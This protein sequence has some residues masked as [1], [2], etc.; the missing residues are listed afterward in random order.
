M[1]LFVSGLSYRTAPVGVREQLALEDDKLREIL[2]DVHATGAVGEALVVSTCNRVEVYGMAEVPG[3]A[4]AI[5][6]RHLCRHRGVDP[7][8]VEPY[9]YTHLEREAV[10]HA[11][12]VAAS[13]D[14]MIVGEPQILGQVKDAFALA[15]SCETIGPALHALFTQ[16]FAVAKKVRTETEIGRHAV[17][18]S[19]AA[20]ELAKKIFSGLG[21]KAVLLV[22]AGKMGELAARHLVEQGAFPIYV[23]NRTWGR[24]QEM[25]RALAGTAVPFDE[26]ATALAAVDIVI[27]ST[28]A[29]API[30]RRD[31]VARVMQGRRA[32]PLF[33]IDIAVPRDVE[34]GVNTLD[35]VYCYD[36]DD[37]RKVVDANRRERLREAERGEAMI[38]REV[39]KFL[40]R[41]ADVAVVPTIV[42]LRERLEV[43]RAGEVK[44]ALTR[45]PSA[46]AETREALEALSTAIV[47]K[48]L[49]APITKLRESSRA[50]SGRSWTEVI[51]ELFGLGRKP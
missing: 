11:F 33:F 3:E 26:L 50:G 40:A 8:S 30:V 31:L 9:L 42:S 6:F 19:F 23:A 43:I 5:A 21:G 29:S 25:A 44:K 14:S 32:R 22:G 39:A 1:A 38:E 45:L 36:I 24:A 16:A 10:S 37:M 41:L 28:G 47:N 51:H 46:S 15:Q 12:R 2:R 34:P 27:T 13:L 49:H 48:V 4:R 17:S 20:I 35:A 7:A 18:V